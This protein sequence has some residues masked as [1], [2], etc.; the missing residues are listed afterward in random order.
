LEVELAMRGK[1]GV[2]AGAEESREQRARQVYA[3]LRTC[4][5]W[6]GVPYWS[7]GATIPTVFRKKETDPFV[8]WFPLN[9]ER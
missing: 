4:H 3:R 9:V 8:P 2:G 5:V 7:V 6:P 1:D